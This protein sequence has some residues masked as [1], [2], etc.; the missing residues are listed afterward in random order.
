M[1]TEDMLRAAAN[2]ASNIYTAD[3][4]N[5]YNP[6]FQHTFSK[7]FEKKIRRLKRKATHPL[8]YKNMQRVASILLAI[9]IAGGAW[10]AVDTEARA[11]FVG[12]IRAVYETYIVLH[13]DKTTDT[14]HDFLDYRP[15]WI[16]EGYN[17]L[18]T[19]ISILRTTVLYS[20]EQGEMLRFNY[21]SG[22][23]ETDWFVDVSQADIKNTTVN[24]HRAEMLIAQDSNEA[25][26]ITWA[27]DE[28]VFYV[29][30]FVNEDDLIKIAE[31]VQIVE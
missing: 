7:K 18:R 20:N 19:N 1:I 9:F 11:V 4:E 2:K 25:N 8:F 10:I 30:G 28:T 24:G 12:W 5:G 6:E 16:P 26:A 23:E 22:P 17:E 3:L 21:S 15:T 27:I 29:T 13:Y 31:S 14:S